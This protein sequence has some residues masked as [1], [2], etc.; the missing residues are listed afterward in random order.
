MSFES[1]FDKMMGYFFEET[2]AAPAPFAKMAPLSASTGTDGSI[3]LTWSGGSLTIPANQRDTFLN[4]VSKA[5]QM[6]K[7]AVP[8]P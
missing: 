5:V 6:S 3:I 7:Q 4:M 2:A 1:T 8:N